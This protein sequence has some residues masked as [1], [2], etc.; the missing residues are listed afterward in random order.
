MIFI[1][2]V[3]RNEPQREKRDSYLWKARTHRRTEIGNR[4]KKCLTYMNL[5]SIIFLSHS[6][7][8]I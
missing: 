7:K 2:G 4:K 8:Y 3:I 1:L 6:E 5:S